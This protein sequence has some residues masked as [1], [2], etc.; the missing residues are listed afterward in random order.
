ML[1]LWL[2]LPLWSYGG[3]VTENIHFCLHSKSMAHLAMI[4]PLSV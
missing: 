2:R 4:S 1:F 3:I